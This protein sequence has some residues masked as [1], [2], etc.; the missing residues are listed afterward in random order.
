MRLLASLMLLCSACATID[1]APREQAPAEDFELKI[2]DV[3]DER[4]F[5]LELVAGSS[6]LCF[7][8]NQWPDHLGRID[9]GSRRATVATD[10]GRSPARDSNFGYC[11]GPGCRI[12]VPAR[13]RI[14]AFI[15]YSEF[16]PESHIAS[17]STRRLEYVIYPRAC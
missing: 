9:M 1:A 15:P 6:P 14:S 13:G 12:R 3:P 10:T 16:P 17:S 4:R 8:I 7:G 2:N 11:Q 5:Q